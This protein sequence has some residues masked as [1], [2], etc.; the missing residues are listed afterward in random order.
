MRTVIIGAAWLIATAAAQPSAPKVADLGWMSGSWVSGTDEDWTEEIWIGPR[1]GVLLGMNLSGKG[2]KS[3]GFEFMRIA[4]DAEGHITF[5]ASPNGK[6]AVP[7]RLVSLKPGEA[8]FENPRHDYPT[9]LVYRLKGGELVGTISGPGGK[10]PMSW[11]L[12]RP[13]R[14]QRN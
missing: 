7:F 2:A 11:T 8:V 12:R 14:A 3:T 9:N 4:A 1:A 5:F 6:P 10:K 13:S